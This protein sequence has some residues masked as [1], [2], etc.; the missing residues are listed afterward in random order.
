M[1]VGG[2]IDITCTLKLGRPDGLDSSALY[3]YE[4][5]MVVG[6]EFVKIVNASSIRLRMPTT[7]ASQ[8]NYICKLKRGPQQFDGVNVVPVSVGHKPTAVENFKCRSDNWVQM[9]CTFGKD[10]SVPAGLGCNYTL[11]F[12]VHKL[13]HTEYHCKLT[14]DFQKNYTCT[15]SNASKEGIYRQTYPKYYFKL[16]AENMLG[17]CEQWIEIDHYN[18]GELR[19]FGRWPKGLNGFINTIFITFFVAVIPAA[20]INLRYTEVTSR[21]ATV[22]WNVPTDMQ[23]FVNGMYKVVVVFESV[24]VYLYKHNL[25][26]IR[27]SVRFTPLN[28]NNKYQ[29]TPHRTRSHRQLSFRIRRW[30]LASDA[31]HLHRFNDAQSTRSL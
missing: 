14:P 1:L 30:R 19:G 16:Q 31:R 4:D 6:N 3:F 9:T 22:I 18:S 10:P 25:T 13:D 28:T 17:R 12:K 11:T 5:N 21:A 27:L 26:I 20:P 15:I 29:F 2:T 7:H 8:H 24:I 23:G